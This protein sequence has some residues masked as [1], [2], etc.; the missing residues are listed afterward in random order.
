MEQLKKST[1]MDQS[2][3]KPTCE[4]CG[5]DHT[6]DKPYNEQEALNRAGDELAREIDKQA[7]LQVGAWM[8]EDKGYSLGTREAYDE[9]VKKRN[10]SFGNTNESESK[11]S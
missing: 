4:R 10:Y 6:N 3:L 5:R 11:G 2:S 9:F 8:D 7:L 1:L